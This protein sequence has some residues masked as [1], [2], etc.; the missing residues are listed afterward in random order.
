MGRAKKTK[1]SQKDQ[2]RKVFTKQADSYAAH[3]PTLDRVSYEWML[4][5]SRVQPSDRVLDAATGPGFI[6]LLFAERAREVTG[7]DLTRALLQ[8]AQELKRERGVRH[9]NFLEGDVEFLPF[10]EGVFDLVTCHKAFHHFPRPERVL[11]E[12]Y[13]VLRQG[14]RLVLG[15]TL[16]SE[17]PQKSELHNRLERMRDSSHVKMYPLSQLTELIEQ[18]G[19]QMEDAVE[20]DDERDFNI[21]MATIT[22]PP[23]VIEKI[24]RV[25]LESVAE[26]RTGQR[27]RVADGTLYYTR[28]S[29]VVAAVK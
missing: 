11:A 14:G 28:F 16:S 24:K 12:L 22:P 6:A 29:A 18:A 4:K 26:D 3:K 17:D 23:E 21:W 9:V 8:K 27:L 2:V 20:F 7:I 5:L 15:D 19:F 10:G 1:R 25:M 13:R